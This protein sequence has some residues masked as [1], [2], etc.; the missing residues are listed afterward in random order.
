MYT[1]SSWWG[2][3]K[4]LSPG[5][6]MGKGKNCHACM[7]QGQANLFWFVS[8]RPFHANTETPLV[9]PVRACLARVSCVFKGFLPF[10]HQMSG[11]GGADLYELPAS[12]PVLLTDVTVAQGDHALFT[13][14]VCGRPRPTV[15]WR[16]PSGAVITTGKRRESVVT[17]CPWVRMPPWVRILLSASDVLQGITGQ[18]ACLGQNTSLS[19]NVFLGQIA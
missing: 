3:L 12:F 15:T 17:T 14:K 6:P 8:K 7:N 18:N 2:P 9:S 16:G 4:A 13:C 10:R 1:L 19:Q 11:G 5:L